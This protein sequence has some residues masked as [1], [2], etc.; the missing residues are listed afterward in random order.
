M[1]L[2]SANMNCSVSTGEG[3]VVNNQGKNET[4]VYYS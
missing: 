1:N 2:S 4:N 3:A